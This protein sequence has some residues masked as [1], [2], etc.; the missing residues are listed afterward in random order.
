[1]KKPIMITQ[2]PKRILKPPLSASAQ[3]EHQYRLLHAMAKNRVKQRYYS[4]LS[5]SKGNGVSYSAVVCDGQNDVLRVSLAYMAIYECYLFALGLPSNFSTEQI[6]VHGADKSQF[7]PYQGYA[8]NGPL[9]YD[10]ELAVPA[11][12]EREEYRQ[13]ILNDLNEHFQLDVRI[14]QLSIVKGSQRIITKDGE[15]VELIW[16]EQP[17][18]IMKSKAR[19]I[20]EPVAQR[21]AARS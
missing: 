19:K 21:L 12:T 17:M 14:E 15:S 11:N 18:M 3:I 20:T 1:M 13:R 16:Q 9:Y 2:L 7:I 8:N 4:F 10:Y 6:I 5:P